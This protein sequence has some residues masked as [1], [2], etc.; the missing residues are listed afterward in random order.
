MLSSKTGEVLWRT[1][2]K[3]P[4]SPQPIHS[5]F[6][7]GDRL[8]GIKLHAGQGFF[9]AGMDCKTGKP[10][11]KFNE[12]N[13]YAGKPQVRLRPTAFGS[14][15]VAEIKD[16]QEFELKSFDMKTGKLVHAIKR[17]ATG[18]F[19]E[20]GRAS[21]TVQNGRM[22]LLGGTVLSRGVKE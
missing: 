18:D 16:R 3:Q 15:V 19:G 5:M 8:Y 4:S 21:A 10:L 13:G 9:F 14:T 11:F 12:Q 7:E 6:I 22:V 2:P 20:H 17:K 1:D